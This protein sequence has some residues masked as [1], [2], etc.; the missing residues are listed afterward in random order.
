MCD[1]AIEETLIRVRVLSMVNA[2]KWIEVLIEKNESHKVSKF[3][4]QAE[5]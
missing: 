3:L 1:W 5:K 4:M 2:W